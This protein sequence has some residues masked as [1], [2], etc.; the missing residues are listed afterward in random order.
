TAEE[1]D[2]FLHSIKVHVE[3]AKLVRN[4]CEKSLNFINREWGVDAEEYIRTR[5]LVG[6]TLQLI[7]GVSKRR[8]VPDLR[9]G[10]LL[11]NTQAVKRIM[12][13]KTFH[14]RRLFLTSQDWQQCKEDPVPSRELYVE[15]LYNAGV[16][17]NLGREICAGRPFL[18]I[19]VIS[20]KTGPEQTGV[21]GKEGQYSYGEIGANA[22]ST[23]MTTSAYPTT[24]AATSSQWVS[25]AIRIARPPTR[26]PFCHLCYPNL[27]LATRFLPAKQMSMLLV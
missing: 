5:G 19:F 16:H 22:P 7:A 1:M 25:L 3:V 14:S 2:T 10:L 24:S 8:D 6:W 27:S 18:P 11:A 9:T 23:T 26:L 13:G 20:D 17:L 4:R 12:E 15:E 21:S